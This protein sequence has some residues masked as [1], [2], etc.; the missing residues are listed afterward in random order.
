M[1]ARDP[2]SLVPELTLAD[3][4]RLMRCS[5]D[6]V[7]RHHQRWTVE[8]GFP[9]AVSL[10]GCR[11]LRWSR[12]AVAVWELQRAARGSQSVGEGAAA[13]DWHAVAAARGAMLDAGLDPDSL[14][15]S[16]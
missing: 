7:R 1:K 16:I 3:V 4:A 12:A 9:R 8:T 5:T 13:T 6:T 15:A 14:P 2:Q 11:G 10:P